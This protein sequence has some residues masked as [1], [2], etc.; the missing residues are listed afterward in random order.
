[1]KI[2]CPKCANVIAVAPETGLAETDLVCGNCGAQLR[3]PGPLEEAV[4]KVKEVMKETEK[5]IQ[6]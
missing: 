3:G 6:D 4:D 5:K 2:I 1:M